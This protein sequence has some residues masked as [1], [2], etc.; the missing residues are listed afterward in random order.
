MGHHAGDLVLQEVASRLS[1]QLRD[2]DFVAR[3]GGDEFAVLIEAAPDVDTVVRIARR[4]MAAF[5]TPMSVGGREIFAST[6]IGITLS[7]PRYSTAEDLLRNADA[8]MYRAKVNGRQ[9]FELFDEHLHNDALRVLE[10]ENAL[11]VAIQK[12]Q[13]R[14]VFQPVVQLD[15]GTVVGYEALMR[16]HHPERGVLAPGE[17]LTLA[18]DNGSIEA[19]DWQVFEQAFSTFSDI[20]DFH[21]SLSVNVAPRHFRD[22]SFG[23]RM[24]SLIGA[25]GIHPARVCLE[26]TEGAL[27]ENPERTSETLHALSAQ[28]V[29]IAL[30]DFGTGYSSLGYL[31]RFPLNV[32]KIDRSF[33]A[34]L[35][36]GAPGQ[37]AKAEAL[38][39]AVLALAASFDLD[40]IAEGIETE[41]QKET[42]MLLGC[43]KGQ[44]YLLGRPG[45]APSSNAAGS[46]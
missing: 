25:T 39:R 7:D 6:S 42:L 12:W 22:A 19:I 9:R 44:G 21:G 26:I 2:P 3:L 23:V 20:A 45:A 33:V 4:L 46:A 41:A 1:K 11:R 43:R 40:V 35:H 30:D 37:C 5:E 31:H 14:P 10:M 17:F 36:Q 8:A 13:I 27:V 32:L 18:E 28:G 15:D 24:M 34:P 29:M 38:V 16:W